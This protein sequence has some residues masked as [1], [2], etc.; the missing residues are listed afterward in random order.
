MDCSRRQ[1]LEQSSPRDPIIIT[2]LASSKELSSSATAR[3]DGGMAVLSPRPPGARRRPRSLL[4]VNLDPTQKA[5]AQRAAGGAMLVL[6]EAGHGKTTVLLHRLAHLYG[7]A[8]G[9]L[10]ARMIVPTEGLRRLLQPLVVRLGADVMVVT[11][12]RFAT[13]QARR[14]FG[15]I[16]HREATSASAGV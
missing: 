3:L 4:D 9:S 8:R 11:Y 5:A 10:S 2:P 13:K 7:T 6:G 15:D 1:P 14:A 16:P 12:D